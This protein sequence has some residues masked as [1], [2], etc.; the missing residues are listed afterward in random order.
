[1]TSTRA[2]PAG[3]KAS[4]RQKGAKRVTLKVVR[5]KPTGSALS[6]GR[7]RRVAAEYVA[8]D[9][10]GRIEVADFAHVRTPMGLRTGT[11]SKMYGYHGAGGELSAKQLA[12]ARRNLEL[13]RSAKRRTR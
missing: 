3:T 6:P 1:M 13:A 11:G 2:F 10:R 8:R 12:A 9:D 7:Y 5:Q 4:S